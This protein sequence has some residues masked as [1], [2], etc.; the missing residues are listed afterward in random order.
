[1]HPPGNALQIVLDQSGSGLLRVGFEE[2][3]HQPEAAGGQ[4]ARRSNDQAP[5]AA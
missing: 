2:S 4:Q 5:E 3:V 1:M